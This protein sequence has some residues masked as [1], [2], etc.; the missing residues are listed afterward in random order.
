MGQVLGVYARIADA[1]GV[2]K[3]PGGRRSGP[4]KRAGIEFD[5]TDTDHTDL[6]KNGGVNGIRAVPG[7]GVIVDASRTLSTDTRW[8][9]VGTPA[10][11]QL[12]QDFA[13]AGPALGRAGA[14]YI[15]HC[16]GA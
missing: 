3:A 1:R 6:V 2:F 8:L 10:P 7:T 15:R 12:R 13:R 11:V 5:M 9:Y 16:W 14:A 4:E